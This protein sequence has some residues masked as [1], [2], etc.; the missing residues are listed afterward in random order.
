MTEP[1]PVV[2]RILRRVYF[3]DSGCWVWTGGKSPSGYGVTSIDRRQVRVHRAVYELFVGPI[4]AGLQLDHLCRVRAC[5][6]PDHLEPVTCR[7]NLL[8]GQ[9]RAAE[10]ALKD[11]CPKGHPYDGFGTRPS[12]ASRRWC[13]TCNAQAARKQSA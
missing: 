10:N 11:R 8:R 7:E 12:G 2:E 9:T 13:K 3:A 1:S 4:P 6:N 5:C